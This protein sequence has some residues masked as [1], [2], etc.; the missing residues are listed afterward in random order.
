LLAKPVA[1]S[2]TSKFSAVLI[3]HIDSR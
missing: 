1:Q 2:T 3:G